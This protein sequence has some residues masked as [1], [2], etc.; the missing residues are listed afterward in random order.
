MMLLAIACGAVIGAL[1]RYAVMIAMPSTTQDGF[2]WATLTVNVLGSF[3]MGALIETGAVA[4]GLSP[5]MRAFL[6]T[7]ILASFTTFSTFS[8]DMAALIQRNQ[9]M[10]A[11]LYAALSVGLSVAALFIGLLMVKKLG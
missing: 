11:A 8:L 6:V 4:Q 7:G 3:L 2:P 9:T 1:S 10:T 5:T